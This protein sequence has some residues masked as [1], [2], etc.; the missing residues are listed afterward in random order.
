M[1]RVQVEDLVGVMR[2]LRESLL[3]KIIRGN[4]K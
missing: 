2:T 4:G 3:P 1:D